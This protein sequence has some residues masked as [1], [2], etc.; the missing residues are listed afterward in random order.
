MTPLQKQIREELTDDNW[1]KEWYWLIQLGKTSE[2]KFVEDIK[3]RI[4]LYVENTNKSQNEELVR[5]IKEM[6]IETVG[7]S[8]KTVEQ[9]LT[10]IQ[11]QNY[12]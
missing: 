5:K 1:I 10:I 9:I 8:A 12:E 6:P 2:D 4:C 11:S 7:N 3:H